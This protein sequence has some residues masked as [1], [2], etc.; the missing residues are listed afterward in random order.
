MESV[1]Y[2]RFIY[3]AE[4]LADPF[5]EVLAKGL[6][7]VQPEARGRILVDTVKEACSYFKESSSPVRGLESGLALTREAL[8]LEISGFKAHPIHAPPVVVN[9]SSPVSSSK[10]PAIDYTNAVINSIILISGF[11]LAFSSN[12]LGQIIGVFISLLAVFFFASIQDLLAIDDQ[13]S[14]RRF[15][16]RSLTRIVALFVIWGAHL[17]IQERIDAYDRERRAIESELGAKEQ[18]A[19]QSERDIAIKRGSSSPAGAKQGLRKEH[20]RMLMAASIFIS[21]GFALWAKFYCPSILSLKPGYLNTMIYFGIA[22]LWCQTLNR[23]AGKQDSFNKAKIFIAVFLYGTVFGIGWYWSYVAYG[24]LI[25]TS[26]FLGR[27]FTA[28]VDQG[29]GAT[30]SVLW[31]FY[32]CGVYEKIKVGK[33]KIFLQRPFKVFAEI[34]NEKKINITI[35]IIA[36]WLIWGVI[37]YF[38]LGSQASELEKVATVA[39]F[40][41]PWS[42]IWVAM[43]NLEGVN[44]QLKAMP[45][46]VVGFGL[47]VFVGFFVFCAG[48]IH[49]YLGLTSEAWLISVPLFGLAGAVVANLKPYEKSVTTAPGESISS[50]PVSLGALVTTI[51]SPVNIV[52]SNII[53][54]IDARAL[55]KTYGGT[56][57][58]VPQEF[59]TWINSL[60]VGTIWFKGV[61]QKSKLSYLLMQIW[62]RRHNETLKR[63][64]SAYDIF[65]YELD[66][67]IA[68]NDEEFIQVVSMLKRHGTRT[69]LDFVTNHLAFDSPLIKGVEGLVLA[70]HNISAYENTEVWLGTGSQGASQPIGE[71]LSYIYHARAGEPGYNPP[72]VNL[73]QINYMDKR[74]RE[75]MIKTVLA[76]IAKLT[77]GGGLRADLAFLA[78]RY[79]FYDTWGRP[80]GMSWEY[81][82]EQMPKEFW[83]EF[84]DEV[85]AQYSGMLVLAESYDYGDKEGC[86]WDGRGGAFTRL[87]IVPYD[88]H[89]FDLQK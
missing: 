82:E 28:F 33:G 69:I 81:F 78:F 73:A 88:K 24:H 43:I 54:E 17:T 36:S 40:E 5:D 29:A 27:F 58:D 53:L 66:S 45:R 41:I 31:S 72:M 32:V 39:V 86:P 50:S 38:N 4:S 34:W 35:T 60:G 87:G 3:D 18:P 13:M 6:R 67:G 64:A 76:K 15:T 65:D 62:S 9:S 84:M 85:N 55:C 42:I 2:E 77:L 70:N 20:V 22:E 21:A 7:D 23:I 61:W 30:T 79:N 10:A 68:A 89:V 75:Y 25:S 49:H 51:S 12:S 57:K 63:W 52:G 56:I 48:I 44:L 37:Q 16:F 80:Y 83:Q 74:A 11:Y 26:N 71:P 14:V 46:S 59:W 1:L 19:G 8:I 47:G